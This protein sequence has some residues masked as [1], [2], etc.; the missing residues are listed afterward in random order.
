MGNTFLDPVCGG[1]AE[2]VVSDTTDGLLENHHYRSG[3]ALGQTGHLLDA[4]LRE[5]RDRVCAFVVAA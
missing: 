1:A 3:Q 4:K 2:G 5:I